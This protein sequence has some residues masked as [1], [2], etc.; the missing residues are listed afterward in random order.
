MR[1]NRL[2]RD[3]NWFYQKYIIERLSMSEIG[4]ICAVSCSTI[5]RELKKHGIK[6]RNRSEA[7]KGRKF[8][9]V[10]RKK[11][12]LAKKGCSFTEEHKKKLSIVRIGVKLSKETRRKMA[13]SRRKFYQ[14][15]PL[16]RGE[17]HHLW[18]KHRSEKTKEKLRETS[19]KWRQENP[20]FLRG[21]NSPAWLGGISFEPYGI[22]F[23]EKL[24][25]E[26]RKR[27]NYACQMLDCNAIQNGKKFPIHH[28]DYNK[29]NNED[30]N[31]VTLCHSCH[32]KTN[33]N[34]EYWENYFKENIICL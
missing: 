21:K 17:K 30:W 19:R 29:R 32:S 33:T 12:S 23:N 28:K 26:I 34:R 14:K 20:D 11:I 4:K 18:G 13:E 16:P 2:Y 3:K 27:D 7:L 8:T 25:E 22:E 31:L 15:Y 24:K 1:K 9:K 6:T 5:F 10:W